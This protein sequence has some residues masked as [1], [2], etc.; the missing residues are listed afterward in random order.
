MNPLDVIE[1]SKGN[2]TVAAIFAGFS[3]TIITMMM[4]IEKQKRNDIHL[5]SIFA[6]Y[7]SL[8]ISIVVSIAS[9]YIIA[10]PGENNHQVLNFLWKTSTTVIPTFFL[11][12]SCLYAFTYS[13]FLGVSVTILSV[14][15]IIAT[16]IIINAIAASYSG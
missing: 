8:V 2:I 16:L 5:M 15:A 7:V 14:F 6:F 11:V 3:L 10:Y 1:Y 12:G 4:S 13:K 9:T